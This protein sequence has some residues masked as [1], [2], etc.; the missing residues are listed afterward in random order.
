MC[1]SIRIREFRVTLALSVARNVAITPRD[2][3][4]CTDD[5]V[6]GTDENGVYA[7]L[8]TSTSNGHLNDKLWLGMINH[9]SLWSQ[10]L[11]DRDRQVSEF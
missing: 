10:H 2:G 3:R 1:E 11:R 6:L 8:F 4:V 7:T 9:S 5:S